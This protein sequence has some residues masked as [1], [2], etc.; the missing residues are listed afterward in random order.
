MT[1]LQ[2]LKEAYLP[3]E[4]IDFTESLKKRIQTKFPS[5]KLETGKGISVL[6]KHGIIKI[7][8]A[9]YGKKGITMYQLSEI[10]R[11]ITENDSVTHQYISLMKRS[12]HENPKF[13]TSKNLIFSDI[14]KKLQADDN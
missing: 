7:F 3:Q 4:I 14:Y 13:D 12:V 2:T 6:V 1:D 10:V 9:K 11:F 5:V 8:D